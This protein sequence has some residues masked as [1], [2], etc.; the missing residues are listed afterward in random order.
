M[1]KVI[2]YAIEEDESGCSCPKCDLLG[3]YLPLIL[4]TNGDPE[5][6]IEL[7]GYLIDESAELD[8]EDDEYDIEKI[9]SDS[10]LLG[11]KARVQEEV[12]L[13]QLALEKLDSINCDC[14]DECEE[15]CC[16]DC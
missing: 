9:E 10:F 16:E 1:A 7:L 4:D 14:C 13:G 6:L 15:E 2:R 5:E 12:E 11:Y 3:E 8:L